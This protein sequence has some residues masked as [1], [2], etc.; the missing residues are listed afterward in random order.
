M[1]LETLGSVERHKVGEINKVYCV[2]VYIYF[3]VLQVFFTFPFMFVNSVQSPRLRLGE[4]S[5]SSVSLRFIF[6]I[7]WTD[8][9]CKSLKVPHNHNLGS[10]N[11]DGGVGE[12]VVGD[13]WWCQSP[14]VWL[15]VCSRLPGRRVSMKGS[16]QC[17]V[18]VLVGLSWR[19][20]LSYTINY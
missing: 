13:G 15:S 12:V 9:A 2:F 18:L 11:G 1:Q 10:I 16:E 8:I 20:H 4:L 6:K 3:F 19:F 17:S 14:S 5:P 7:S